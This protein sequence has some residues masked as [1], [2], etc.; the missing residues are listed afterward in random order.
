MRAP[1]GAKRPVAND[2]A[3]LS[4]ECSAAIKFAKLTERYEQLSLEWLCDANTALHFVV[5]SAAASQASRSAIGSFGRAVLR[6]LI[7][8]MLERIAASHAV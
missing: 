2:L 6:A 4:L 3:G 7:K 1:Y 8:M 5:S